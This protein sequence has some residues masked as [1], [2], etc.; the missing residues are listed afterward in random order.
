[1]EGSF[2]IRLLFNYRTEF[3]SA[4]PP[5]LLMAIDAK[6]IGSQ[7]KLFKEKESISSRRMSSCNITGG[8]R[9]VQ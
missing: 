1:M 9:G 6:E 4:W 5:Y 8:I 2:P 7:A 3:Q